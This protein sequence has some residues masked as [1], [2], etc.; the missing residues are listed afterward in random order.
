LCTRYAASSDP[1]PSGAGR[2]F[3]LCPVAIATRDCDRGSGITGG[4]RRPTIAEQDLI[5]CRCEEISKEEILSA[6]EEGC[7][8]VI[9]V[10]RKTRAGMGLC[11]GRTCGRLVARLVAQ[12][13][14]KDLGEVLP[15]TQRPPL[16]PIPLD[17]LAEGDEP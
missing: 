17:I 1:G 6:I 16:R 2:I 15:D 7:D 11:Q 14:G 9:W 5:V 8:S 3:D 13:T 10:K 12:E 4:E